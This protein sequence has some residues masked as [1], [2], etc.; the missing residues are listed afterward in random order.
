MNEPSVQYNFT[1]VPDSTIGEVLRLAEAN[2]EDAIRF[3]L[4]SDQRAAVQ[5][6]I[7]GAIAAGALGIFATFS[8]DASMSGRYAVLTVAAG[9]IAACFLSVLAARPIDFMPGGYHPKIIAEQ[10]DLSWLQRYAAEDIARRIDFNAVQL[11]AAS[12]LTMA[13]IWCAFATIPAAAL[14]LV[15]IR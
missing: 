7:F 8:T 15:L 13:A 2:L 10:S 5:A 12:K 9:M 6:G 14:A 3:G 4:A 1:E 11:R